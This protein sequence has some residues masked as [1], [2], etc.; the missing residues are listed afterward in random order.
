MLDNPLTAFELLVDN[1]MLTHAQQFTEAE[2][3][4]VKNSD[5]WKL[6][7]SELKVFIILMYLRGALR[8][9]DFLSFGIKIGEY[10]FFQKLWV[11]SVFAKL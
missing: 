3:Q 10:L 6:P 8:K 1:S 4:K 2:A 9:K 5:E 11:E 7:L